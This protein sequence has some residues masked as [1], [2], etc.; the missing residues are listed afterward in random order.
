MVVANKSITALWVR[1]P[2]EWLGGISASLFVLH[3]VVR[4]FLNPRYGGNVY[5]MLTEY[6]VISIAAAWLLTK[7]LNFIPKPKL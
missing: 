4:C 6:L 5:V 2:F 3:P 7:L 1:K